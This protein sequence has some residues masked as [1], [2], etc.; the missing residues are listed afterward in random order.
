VI[1]RRDTMNKKTIKLM[2]II[3]MLTLFSIMLNV[4]TVLA[5]IE[6]SG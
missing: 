3:A 6:W 2:L 5:G 4:G 1:D